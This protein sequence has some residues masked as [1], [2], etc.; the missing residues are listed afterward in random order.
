MRLAE[1]GVLTDENIDRNVVQFLR[2]RGFDVRDVAEEGLFGK[3]D[4][5]LLHRAVAEHRVVVTHDSDF[6]M[7]AIRQGEPVVGIVYLRPGHIDPK[8]TVGTLAA[9]LDI[10][11]DLPEP[12]LIVARR[13]GNDVTIRIRHLNP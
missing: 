4:A 2:S 11:A 3:A 8:F 13:T 12:F 5:V 9:V 1:Y 10:E 6:G 7:L